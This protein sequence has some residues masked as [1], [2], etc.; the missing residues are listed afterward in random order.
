MLGR[1]EKNKTKQNKT[2]LV[3][4]ETKGFSSPSLLHTSFSLPLKTSKP[5]LKYLPVSTDW[6]DHL[7]LY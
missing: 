7:P 4:Q 1:Q 6:V 5:R 2:K 3:S